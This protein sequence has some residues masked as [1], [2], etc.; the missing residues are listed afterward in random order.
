MVELEA[1]K[2][3]RPIV[4]KI[5]LADGTIKSFIIDSASTVLEVSD[6]LSDKL[7]MRPSSQQNG[8][9][10]MEVFNNIERDLNTDDKV[11]DSLAKF[12]N[13][14]VAMKEQKMTI[15]AK[16]IFKKRLFLTRELDNQMERELV[17]H[18]TVTDLL[19]GVL[20]CADEEV[21]ALA[22]LKLQV[23]FI[24]LDH[25]NFIFHIAYI[26]VVRLRRLH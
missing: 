22:A 14:Q 1:L 4:I 24:I 17:F 8:F 18:Q 12:E 7:L 10:I 9:T 25:Q 2:D 5:H 23:I 13:L 26:V 16:L 11:A 15:T 19:M 21:V 6:S 3:C 20:P